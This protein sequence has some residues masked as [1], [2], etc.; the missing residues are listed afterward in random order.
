MTSS[1]ISN[2]AVGRS[3]AE[4][5]AGRAESTP[6]A[7]AFSFLGDD[8]AEQ[9]RVTYGQLHQRA[10]AIGAALVEA[11][12]PGAHV[13][14][15]LPPGLDY[16]AAIFGCLYA[17]TVAVTAAPP[18]PG[19]ADRMMPRLR[20][21]VADAHATGVLSNSLVRSFTHEL[22]AGRTGRQ[23]VT[24]LD[25][26]TIEGTETTPRVP[27]AADPE[28]LALLQ[29][30]SGSTAHPRGVMLCH[31]NL[32]VNCSAL[33]AAYRTHP[34]SVVFSWLPP[35]HDMGLIGAILHPVY[36]G[37][38]CYITSPVSVIRRPLRWLQGMSRYRGTFSGGPNFMYD[39]CVRRCGPEEIAALDL[40]RW[41][42]AVNGSEPVRAAT[43]EAFGAA[44]APAGFRRSALVPSYGLAEA[45]LLLTASRAGP[46]TA[47]FDA[48]A[49]Q[50]GSA[51]PEP[52][53][54]APLVGNGDTDAE[55]K[56]VIVDPETLTACPEGTVGE[57]WATGPSVA[58]GY[59]RASA[60][61]DE[62]F[63][64]R[65]RD[66]PRAGPFLRTGDLGFVHDGQLFIVGRRK[67]TII[68]NGANYHPHDLEAFAEEADPRLR[69]HCSA[70]FSVDDGEATRVVLV[71]EVTPEEHGDEA[72]TAVMA[73]VRHRVAAGTGL[74]VDS[75]VLVP[76]RS[77]PKTT[78]GKIQRLRCRSRLLAGELDV[79]AQWH[80]A[81]WWR[82]RADA[83]SSGTR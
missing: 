83:G 36:V 80:V 28:R 45:T 76:R 14:L 48:D 79:V 23:E 26:D 8:L 34:E 62:I 59:W 4:V 77:I 51:V 24:W 44:L 60:A 57:V 12:P 18:S 73:E 58:L 55:H 30:T 54:G 13:L 50:R 66:D 40:S 5:L 1:A 31:R 78:S 70:A 65:L 29:Y 9:E 49:L 10:S 42:V 71:M 72:L 47:R 63:G 74:R 53:T 43:L 64:A 19:Q 67:E 25:V 2:T 32:M 3:L 17:G 61:T 37:A 22:A 20:A 11:L 56:V 35:Y 7:V 41:E 16:V 82:H 52:G 6:E 81:G 33:V 69:A 38:R 68:V 46:V 27:R 39:M 15:L 21:I 75:I